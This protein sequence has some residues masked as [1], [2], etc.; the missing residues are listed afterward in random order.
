MT[1]SDAMLPGLHDTLKAQWERDLGNAQEGVRRQL[2]G[3]HLNDDFCEVDARTHSSRYNVIVGDA[4]AAVDKEKKGKKDID[5]DAAENENENEN[6]NKDGSDV[7][8]AST[9]SDATR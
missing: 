6:E 9:A 8:L 3:L 7:A 1:H 2:H 4:D 5:I